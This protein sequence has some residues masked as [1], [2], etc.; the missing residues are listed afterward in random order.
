MY[1]LPNKWLISIA[2]FFLLGGAQ[3]SYVGYEALVPDTRN[4]L[5]ESPAERRGRW[6]DT[7][8]NGSLKENIKLNLTEALD[9]KFVFQFGEYGRGYTTLGFFI[10]GLLVGRARLFENLESHRKQFARYAW[11]AL[12]AVLLLYFLKTFL[13]QG[14]LGTFSGWLATPIDSL[15]NIFSSFIWVVLIINVYR[16]VRVQARMEKVVS[17]GRKGLTNYIL[18]SIIGVFIFS[19]YGLGWHGLGIS[20]SVL[21]CLIYTIIQIH[22]SHYWLEKFRYGPIEWLWRSGTYL[23]WQPL[24]R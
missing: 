21:L 19:G 8:L 20:L 12:G 11:S 3:L 16:N 22:L 1:S 5:V 17:Y 24:I 2:L 6:Q 18:Q 13:P 4:E 15:I 14:S 10:L 23:K 9:F 7:F